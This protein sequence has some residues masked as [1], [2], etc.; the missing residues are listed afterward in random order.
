MRLDENTLE[1]NSARFNLERLNVLPPD[2]QAYDLEVLTAKELARN[3][4]KLATFAPLQKFGGAP[5]VYQA[6]DGEEWFL[7]GFE[8]AVRVWRA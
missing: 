4:A 5:E 6:P 2:P 1:A 7:V 8:D 3:A